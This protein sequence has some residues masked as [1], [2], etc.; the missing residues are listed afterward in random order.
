MFL[1]NGTIGFYQL[2]Y[3]V[4]FLVILTMTESHKVNKKQHFFK[5]VF[6]KFDGVKLFKSN[7]L[8]PPKS[9]IFIDEQK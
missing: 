2:P 6:M 3:S 4:L 8:K 5:M 9:D 1:V 7:I